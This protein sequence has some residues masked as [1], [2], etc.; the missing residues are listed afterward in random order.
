MCNRTLLQN[1]NSGHD[2]VVQTQLALPSHGDSI[3]YIH[4]N[5]Y[6]ETWE[7]GIPPLFNGA[8]LFYQPLAMV[9]GLE[10]DGEE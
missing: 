9:Q 2:S 1:Q 7:R 6:I 4:D 10:M 5:V 3:A 8:L